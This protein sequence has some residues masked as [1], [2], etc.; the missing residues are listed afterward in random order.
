M[1]R[2]ANGPG[3]RRKHKKKLALAKGF[4]NRRKN[5]IRI[6]ALRVDR[7]LQYQYRDRR[8]KKRDFRALWIQR[9][10]AGTRQEGMSYSRFMNGLKKANIMLDRKVLAHLAMHD[11][12]AFKTLVEQAKKAIA[13]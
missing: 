2:A 7:A 10:N 3:N 8:N 12:A 13:K 1:T 11:N 9:I 5:C 6:G 4:F